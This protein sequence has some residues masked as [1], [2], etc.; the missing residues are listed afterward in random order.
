MPAT[1]LAIT[2]TLLGALVSGLLQHRLA[3]AARTEAR[4]AQHRTDQLGAVTDLAVALSNHRRA[5]WK[6]RDAHLTSADPARITDLHD[7]THHTRAAITSPAVRVR[8]LITDRTVRDAAT[9]AIT[10]TYTMR[11]ATDLTHL[12][13]LRQAALATHDHLVEETAHHL[14]P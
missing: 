13:T 10:A 5:M 6:S 14:T 9:S 3:H 1:L 7:E 11:D 8:L 4:T 12:E 2:G